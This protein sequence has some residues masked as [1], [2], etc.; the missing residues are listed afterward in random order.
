MP[1]D[2]KIDIVL[3]FQDEASV[4]TFVSECCTQVGQSPNYRI[5]FEKA[6][7]TGG[8]EYFRWML[9]GVED[10]PGPEF[11]GRIFNENQ[12]KQNLSYTLTWR[13]TNA[14]INLLAGI[15]ARVPGIS[16]EMYEDEVSLGRPGEPT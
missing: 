15:A 12:A 6:V 5:D 11:T 10:E 7:P 14:P 2:L 8:D 9:W 13:G 16:I 4:D 1:R 3:S